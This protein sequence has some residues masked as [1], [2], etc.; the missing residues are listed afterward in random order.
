MS[1][2]ASPTIGQDNEYVYG[3]LLGMSSREISDLVDRKVIY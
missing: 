2:R 1:R 3:E